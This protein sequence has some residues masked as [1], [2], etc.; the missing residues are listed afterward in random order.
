MSRSRI[1]LLTQGPSILCSTTELPGQIKNK[2]K[3]FKLKEKNK[4][5]RKYMQ[6]IWG[7]MILKKKLNKVLI[8]LLKLKH[9]KLLRYKPRYLDIK[10]ARPLK[11]RRARSRFC[12]NLDLI[13][14]LSFYHGGLRRK[15]LKQYIAIAKKKKGIYQDNFFS[16]LELRLVIIVFRMNF[17][18]TILECISL[19]ERGFILVN[20][21]VIKNINFIVTIGMLIEIIPSYRQEAY[22]NF[23]KKQTNLILAV[24]NFLYI[25]YEIMACIVVT[26]PLIIKY[27]FKVIEQYSYMLKTRRL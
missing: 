8:Y 21:E 23:R 7:N 6:D 18:Y 12:K 24:P 19:I 2:N 27:P 16:L 1:E 13:K 10:I 14:K 5:C 25:N 17:C 26:V 9:E 20:K 22:N 3:M 4:L 11:R 15:K